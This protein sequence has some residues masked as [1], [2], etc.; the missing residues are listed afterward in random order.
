MANLPMRHNMLLELS[1]PGQGQQ[2]KGVALQYWIPH[3]Y[4][5]NLEAGGFCKT[6]HRQLTSSLQVHP[7]RPTQA[8]LSENFY[9]SLRPSQPHLPGS[10]PTRHDVIQRGR[11]SAETP[12]V[13]SNL[14]IIFFLKQ[15]GWST[16][17]VSRTLTLKVSRGRKEM[18]LKL[19]WWRGRKTW[20]LSFPTSYFAMY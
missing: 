1:S 6:L 5:C 16:A 7:P 14:E 9:P 15:P 11:Q 2:W 17:V 19:W 8:G 10:S 18:F 20:V 3:R 4:K 13:I 12:W